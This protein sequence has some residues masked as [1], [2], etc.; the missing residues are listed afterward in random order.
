MST[1]EKVLFVCTGNSCRSQM[2]EG[3]ARRLR[4]DI[5]AYSA[6]VAPGDIVD[7]R[8]VHVMAESGV[9]IS[10]QR[11]KHVRAVDHIDFDLVVTLC[12]DAEERCPV[13]LTQTKVIHVP[14]DDPATLAVAA[15]SDNQAL[16]I[17]RSTRDQLRAFVEKLTP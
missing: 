4:P 8:A 12:A 15:Q 6:G 14:F 10:G 13:F 11:P 9:D 3:W 1:K 17:Y 7:P 2:A 16:P 5:E